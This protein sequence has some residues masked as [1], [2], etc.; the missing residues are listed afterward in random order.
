MTSRRTNDD[1]LT[2]RSFLRSAPAAG[3]LVGPALGVGAASA[4]RPR[5]ASRL[6]RNDL[7]ITRIIAQ[8]AP[9]RRATPV[10]PNA[11]AAYRGYRVREPLVRVQTDQGIEGVTR[12][13]NAADRRETLEQLIGLNPFDLINWTDDRYDGP[14]EP[15]RKL[16]RNLRG[17]D[18]AIFDILGKATRRPLAD[19][20][21]PRVRDAVDVY[22]STLYM[23]DLLTDE[24]KVGLAYLKGDEPPRDD[25]EMVARK[26]DW[27]IN[28]YY[29]D[30]G[31]RIFKIKTGRAKWM[32]SF[33]AALQRD[34][35]VFRA[36]RN[37][38]GPHYTLFA[39]VNNG[40]GEDPAAAKQFIEQTSDVNLFGIEEMFPHDRI[41]AHRDVVEHIHG[42][43]LGVRNIDGETSGIPDKSLDATI[44]TPRGTTPLFD[45]NNP[46]F[47]HR[48]GFVHV[49]EI[50][51]KCRPNGIDVAP[52]NFA[53]K[54]GFHAAVHMGMTVPNWAF[55]EV[56]DSEFP[57]LRRT[58]V[59]VRNGRAEL[60]GEPGLGV[61]V[62]EHKLDTPRFVIE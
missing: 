11:Y 36:V 34:V 13:F 33:D 43:G 8:D 59:K 25:A 15:Y 4:A 45:I 53:S 10:A 62:I 28:D 16:M 17:F 31:V 38:V 9:G 48:Y 5:T 2:R 3:L 7:K 20:L 32:D 14:A 12:A 39:D 50:A 47:S 37:A 54:I 51:E 26:A 19:V 56:D 60:T 58:G 61:D 40:Y 35:D 44:E 41:D 18:I 23:D 6:R 49:A 52:H 24:Q 29:R 1:R 57:G 46:S 30:E 42:L 55:V 27:L 22:D 21:G